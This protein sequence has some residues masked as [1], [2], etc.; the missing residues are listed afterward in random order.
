MNDIAVII[1]VYNKAPSVLQKTLEALFEC[2]GTE[3]AHLILVDDGSD[4]K[5]LEEYE[6][7]IWPMIE[8]SG[9]SCEIQ[10][11][12]T[13]E[14]RPATY[15][16]NSHNNP[17]Y[18][19]NLGIECAVKSGAK[20]TVIMGSDVLLETAA[21]KRAVD[22]PESAAVVGKTVDS[23]RGTVFCSSSKLWPMYW[24]VKA[25]TAAVAAVGFD[26]EYLKG[27][28]FE[29]N[30]FMGRLFLH[31][32]HLVID[33]KIECIHQH[34]APTAYSDNMR[35]FKISEKYTQ[36]K[37]GGVPFRPTDVALNWVAKSSADKIS[38]LMPEAIYLAQ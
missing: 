5:Y 11:S 2:E 29:D 18:A 22:Y 27:M 37:W 34:H 12:N 16:I 17:A 10:Y 1:S 4:D 35:G 25:A 20:T 3:N 23:G 31:T 30:D 28:A 26:E 14:A 8:D 36:K 38:L 6:K 13:I 15:H 9:I 32:K 21:I 33:D 24:F 7:L 19:H